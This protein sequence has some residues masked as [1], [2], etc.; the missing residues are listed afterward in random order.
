ME[1]TY[2]LLSGEVV[3]LKGLSGSERDA[4]KRMKKIIADD[5]EG[6]GEGNFFKLL[7]IVVRFPQNSFCYRVLYDIAQRAGMAQNIIPAPE[8]ERAVKQAKFK[9]S[10]IPF[11][12]AVKHSKLKFG[13][14]RKLLENK[15][16]EGIK[17]G[18]V[19]FVVF[20]SL[21]DYG[22]SKLEN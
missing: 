15:T 8:H 20:S 5:P 9:F 12:T 18:N 3:S 2:V 22:K 11:A 10:T 14:L 19:W 7:K 4:M 17:V 1:K 16:I 21:E 13:E 6:D